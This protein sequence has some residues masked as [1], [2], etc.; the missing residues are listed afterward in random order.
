[1]LYTND[2]EQWKSHYKKFFER[3]LRECTNIKYAPIRL[4]LRSREE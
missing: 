1:M 4:I 3:R 2:P